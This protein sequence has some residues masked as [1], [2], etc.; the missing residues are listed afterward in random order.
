MSISP[1]CPFCDSHDV[2]PLTAIVDVVGYRCHDCVKTF[3]VAAGKLLAEV[4]RVPDEADRI[5]DTADPT[6][7][8]RKPARRSS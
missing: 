4:G 3:Y 2:R 6:R 8:P 7:R 5:P 1:R